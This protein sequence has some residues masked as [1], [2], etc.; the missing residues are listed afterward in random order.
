MEMTRWARAAM[1]G[2]CAGDDN[3][4]ALGVEFLE[5]VRDLDA[6]F[7]IEPARRLVGQEERGVIDE[8][9]GDGIG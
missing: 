3:G 8:S 6:G 4:F 2:S 7:G 9:A 1:S 5:E